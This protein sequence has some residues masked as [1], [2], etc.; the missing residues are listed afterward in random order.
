MGESSLAD[1][2]VVDFTTQLSGPYC[3]RLL[4]D[5]GAD[6]IK[7]ERSD[8]GDDLRHAPPFVDGESASFRVINRNKRSV[9]LD[10]KD[11]RDLDACKW[12]VASADVVVES[13][14]P[15]VMARLG[16]DYASLA[17][18]REDLIYCSVSGFGQTGPLRDQGGF[19]LITQAMSGLMSITGEVEGSPL[20]IPVPVSDLCAGM[21][22]AIGILSAIHART[23]TG[24]GQL[25]DT[26]LFEA[27]LSL[28]NYEAATV[29]ATGEEPERLGHA[30]RGS[31]PYQDF[32]ARDGWLVIGAANQQLWTRLCDAL[33]VEH[34]A[35][36]PRFATNRDRVA[37]QRALA[38]ELQAVFETDTVARWLEK[39]EAAGIPAGPVLSYKEAYA[40]PQVRAREMVT[41]ESDGMRTLGIP[42]KLSET[43]GALRRPAPRLG[44]H[45][46]EV[47]AEVRAAAAP[48]E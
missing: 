15:G 4:A 8:R 5:L 31:A 20:R 9:A 26:S 29:F 6:V 17:E 13:F 10:L 40:H 47:L 46:D 16:L 3:T 22:A 7:I 1:L 41:E 43:P 34:L 30:H 18:E 14:R 36:D 12:L 28:G 25:V 33:N 44:E 45:T 24:R 32:R 35:S 37:N 27:A 42:M 38:D 19:D 21:F 11:P 2:R 39:L 48:G 23:R